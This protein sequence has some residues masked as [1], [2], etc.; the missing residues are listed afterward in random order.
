MNKAKKTARFL[1][2][3]EAPAIE[4]NIESFDSIILLCCNSCF[5]KRKGIAD[6]T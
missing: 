1:P 4:R 2:A 5:G 6:S 3:C